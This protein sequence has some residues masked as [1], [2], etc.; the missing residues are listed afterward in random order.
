M[1]TSINFYCSEKFQRSKYF[2]QEKFAFYCIKLITYLVFKHSV[3]ITPRIGVGTN[4]YCC[5]YR[6]LLSI[7]STARTCL[8]L[9]HTTAQI[10]LSL[11]HAVAL[12]AARMSVLISRYRSPC[13]LRLY[14]CPCRTLVLSLSNDAR[15]RRQQ[16][17]TRISFDLLKKNSTFYI[18]VFLGRNTYRKKAGNLFIRRHIKKFANYSS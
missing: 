5:S 4:L 2:T 1:I 14:L 8:S 18:D 17:A 13:L 7:L 11:S 9:S 15:R 10:C 12:F 6:T 16:C 3:W